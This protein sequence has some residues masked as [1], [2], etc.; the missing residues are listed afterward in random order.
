MGGRQLAGPRERPTGAPRAQGIPCTVRGVRH[1]RL[2]CHVALP[3]RQVR[4][5]LS[6][7]ASGQ[8]SVPDAPGSGPCASPRLSAHCIHSGA[9]EGLTDPFA[10]SGCGGS[11]LPRGPELHPYQRREGPTQALTEAQ[12]GSRAALSQS[13]GM[14][15]HPSL[16]YGGHALSAFLSLVDSTEGKI[17]LLWHHARYPPRRNHLPPSPPPNSS[18]F[19]LKTKWQA[20]FAGLR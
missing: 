12:G 3:Q 7:E 10:G 9:S 1:L 17:T 15:Q 19:I 2:G 11:T 13:V 5:V 8:W 4:R 16:P 20:S 14:G 18:R 6:S